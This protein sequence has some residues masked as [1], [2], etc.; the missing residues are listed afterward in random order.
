MRKSG[1]LL[2]LILSLCAVPAVSLGITIEEAVVT[3]V[4]PVAF[5]V[6]WLVQEPSQVSLNVFNFPGCSTPASGISV[7]I[8]SAAGTGISKATVTGLTSNAAYCYQITAT[9]QTTLES[10]FFP[11]TPGIV[12]TELE[13]TRSFSSGNSLIPFSN[14][15]LYAPSTNG[16]ILLASV[17]GSSYP[18]SAFV[19]DGISP[20]NALMDLN[21]LFKSA[22]RETLNLLGDERLRLLEIRGTGGCTLERW[23]KVPLDNDLAEIKAPA[24]CFDKGDLDCNN[25]VNILDILRDI[26]GFNTFDTGFCFNS[27]LDMDKNGTVNILDILYIVGRFGISG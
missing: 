4:T 22:T 10:A 2:C 8:S 18:V 3:D 5:S 24:A 21:N 23:R 9:S 1:R 27:D 17:T 26:G 19:G 25:T 15:V 20:P 11:A 7:N 16:T 12:M 14:D 13:I 6:V